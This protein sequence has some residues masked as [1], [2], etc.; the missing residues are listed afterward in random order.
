[1]RDQGGA[2]PTAP[3]PDVEQ[4]AREWQGPS[5]TG[6]GEDLVTGE[7]VFGVQN[8][9]SE[10]RLSKLEYINKQAGGGCACDLRAVRRV[11]ETWG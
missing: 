4:M 5:Q 8:Q 7:G 3:I 9:P 2:E 11:A 10:A 1:M 6:L